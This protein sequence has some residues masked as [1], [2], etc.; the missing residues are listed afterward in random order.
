MIAS[1][2]F[3]F[4]EHQTKQVQLI[5]QVIASILNPETFNKQ[6]A[7]TLKDGFGLY[8][9][10]IYLIDSSGRWAVIN[11]A[12]GAASQAMIQAGYRLALDDQTAVGRAGQNRQACFV[13]P[14][15]N[16]WLPESQSELALPLCISDQVIG[17]LDIHSTIENA[18]DQEI[19]ST[20]QTLADQLALAIDKLNDIESSLHE[21]HLMLDMSRRFSAALN[22]KDIY[23]ILTKG[24]VT[25]GV[26][27]CTLY[28]CDE[29]GLDNLPKRAEVVAV[30]DVNSNLSSKGIGDSLELANYPVFE[31]FV[32][33]QEIL[34]IGDIA[35]DERLTAAEQALLQKFGGRSV[36]VNP[37][38]SR[39]H[40]I[41][42]LFIEYRSPHN[43]SEREL[44]LYRTSCNQAT[45]AIEH[46]RQIQRT[47]LALAETQTLYRAGRVLAG[48][49]DLQD[50]LRQALIEFV[51][52]LG[53]DQ[54]GITLITFDRKYGQ[55]MAYLQDGQLQ[56]V[57]KLR[58]PLD[59][60]QPYQKMLLSGQPFISVDAPNDPRLEGFLSFNQVGL[61]KS[62]LEAPMIIHGET[63]GWIGADAIKE[64]RHFTQQEI[65]MARAMADQIS[66][67]IQNRR[68]LEQTERRAEQLKA[69]AKV[70]ESV[71]RM[72]DLREVLNSTV[73]LIR[74]RFG[75]Y[76]VS[77]FL[78]DEAREW[79][80]VHASTGKV[81]KIMVE[82]PHRL[83]V[84]S[85]SIVG[86]VTAN[87]KPRIV[88]DVGEDAVH[89]KNPLLPETRSEMAL[90]LI[91]RG[92]VIGAL[93]VQSREVNAFSDEDIETLQI[94]ADQLATAIEN[95]R[96]FEQ[97]QRRLLEQATLYNIGTK[98]G[99][100]LDLKEATDNLVAETA[101]ALNVAECLLTLIE[102]DD[103][104]Y[105]ISD[106]VDPNSPFVND[107]G[108]RFK[109]ES[110]ADVV[111]V[112]TT[113]QEFI[114]HID[115]SN[116]EGLTFE[117]LKRCQGTA[118][119]LVPVFLRNEV[120]AL[121][122]VYDHTRGRRF[123]DEDITLLDSIAMQAANAIANARLYQSA[124]D[125]QKFMKSII[126]QIPDPI[127]IKDKSHKWIVANRAFAQGLLGRPE[128]EVIGHTDHDYLP[129]EEEADWFWAQDNK[130]FET[131][132][133]QETEEPINTS[134]GQTRILYTRKIPLVDSEGQPEYLIGIVN[135]ITERKQAE[136]TL[137]AAFERTQSL[138][139]ISDALATTTHQQSTAEIVL[140]EYLRLLK[141]TEGVLLF[142]DHTG[143]YHEAQA[144]YAKGQPVK[145]ELILPVAEDP[146][147]Q[148]LLKESAPLLIE[149]TRTHPLT[150]DRRDYWGKARTIL[151]VPLMAR[152]KVVGTLVASSPKA[153][154]TFSPSEI[155]I[156][157]AVADQLSIW[158]ENRQ[159]LAEAQHRSN[160]LQTAAEV[161]RAASSILNA[162]ELINTSV[163][164]IRG[165]FDFYYV[166]LFLVDEAKEWAVLYAGTGEAGR[167]QLERKHRLK[168][169][170]ESMI[171]WCIQNRQARIALDVGREA[172][173]FQNPFL[174]DT[175]SEMAL[176]L[177]SRDEV[178]GALT[179]QSTEQGAFSAEDITLLQT[180][181]DQLA[182][183]I[184]NARLF[185]QT[186]KALSETE[187]L[188]R[189]TQ[190]L[191]AAHDEETVYRLAIEAI[192]QTEV[193]SA[194]IYMYLDHGDSHLAG[195]L[196]EQKAAWT[197]GSASLFSS[198]TRFS[199]ADLIIE[200]LIP[201]HGALVI[202]DT[203]SNDP[204]L[205]DPLRRQLILAGV[206]SLVA[207]PLSTYQ[208]RL[209]FL[210]ITNTKE[211][212]FTPQQL[213]FYNTITQQMVIALENLRLLN[214]S[215]QRARR[216]EIIR[217]ITSK[218]RGATTV[219]DIL[220]TTVTELGQVLGVSRGDI[221]L[222]VNL[223]PA[224][225]QPKTTKQ[226]Q[227]RSTRKDF[228]DGQNGQ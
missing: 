153:K 62:L 139:R 85:N 23:A 209:G 87:A 115:D 206:K 97:T 119:A 194:A 228:K 217:E 11:E 182:N 154:Y 84:G 93:D 77:I 44:A 72:L 178:I 61:P 219:E 116:I 92:M 39:H 49:A 180:M 100:T 149:N 37:L 35:L 208:S 145:P 102:D 163:N 89:L 16:S 160:L 121:L 166:G 36:V 8:H 226:L 126:D 30:G 88:L 165:Q 118:L 1:S 193:H 32:R 112:L 175:H 38:V 200:Q 225:T 164:L 177:I 24:I 158:L 70:G 13:C 57:E 46:A 207:L 190:E 168:I 15:G 27:R 205:T 43:F 42:L 173:R 55:L 156:G 99:S 204:H 96:L 155:E 197:A 159:L 150:K 223:S 138:Y 227:S 172:V 103:V 161:S 224:K 25:T 83:Q 9:V 130:V 120:T 137:K 19:L 146:I 60:N 64:H 29:P 34:I 53:L 132:Q 114:A 214:V 108:K 202:E 174:P 129:Q 5:G 210:I 18:F 195:Q 136:E 91:L 41:G 52:S 48:A 148:H 40:V 216:E 169:G 86:F 4:K 106:Y 98:I 14:V 95:A 10:G 188:Y 212:A 191:L 21:T 66:I 185:A 45:I 63:I 199:S 213:R 179:V 184:V 123:T 20:L 142:L 26:E 80:V 124:Q 113:K 218:I 79:A 31:D 54:G 69:V 141:L 176:P 68:L 94:M 162:N 111:K 128:E 73:D 22:L 152:D 203:T 125:S 110:A 109:L 196:L 135:D 51:Y 12:A 181:A 133:I 186:Q 107:Q 78:L 56:D 151:A 82:R 33:T 2:N 101:A 134:Q 6:M 192:A 65:D 170:G 220:K 74:D 201:Q 50:I 198:G 17:V 90:P 147:I 131:G 59:E 189:I 105:V 104:G 71:S 187:A 58:F 211:G 143:H 117:Y 28:I 67:A 171:G 76:H 47:E 144:M 167:I 140:G 222:N 75:F 183:A 215:Q 81:G 122:E 127:F 157:A 7:E 221:A 3:S